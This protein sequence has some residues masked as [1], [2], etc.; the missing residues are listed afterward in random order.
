M[1][2]KQL[3]EGKLTPSQ[4]SWGT[5]RLQLAPEASGPLPK[6]LPV[7]LN[8]GDSEAGATGALGGSAALPFS[9]V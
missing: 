8:M 6:A 4:G 1:N 7:V 2:V 9:A 5:G 3:Y